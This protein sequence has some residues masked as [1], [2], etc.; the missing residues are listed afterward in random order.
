[1]EQVGE[2]SRVVRNPGDAQL[3]QQ[4]YTGEDLTVLTSTESAVQGL[5][6]RMDAGR[7]ME[8]DNSSQYALYRDAKGFVVVKPEFGSDA[9]AVFPKI[10]QDDYY[11]LFR[12]SRTREFLKMHPGKAIYYGDFPGKPWQ[13]LENATAV[14]TGSPSLNNRVFAKRYLEDRNWITIFE[15]GRIDLG[16]LKQGNPMIMKD[17]SEKIAGFIHRTGVDAVEVPGLDEAVYAKQVERIVGRNLRMVVKT[18]RALI[19]G[20]G[21]AGTYAPK[22]LD[23]PER[24]RSV[25]IDGVKYDPRGKFSIILSNTGNVETPVKIEKL[26]YR[27]NNSERTRMIKEEIL[28][29]ASRKIGYVLPAE[30]GM[31]VERAEITATTYRYI[32][33]PG[34]SSDDGDN[35]DDGDVKK[36]DVE[37]VLA[38]GELGMVGV[39]QSLIQPVTDIRVTRV[40]YS[41]GKNR[42]VFHVTNAGDEEAY[43]QLSVD[44]S[45]EPALTP[46]KHLSPGETFPVALKDSVTSRPERVETTVFQ[47]R[48]RRSL[49]YSS[50]ETLEV[51]SRMPE[52]ARLM[53]LLSLVVLAVFMTLVALNEDFDLP[54]AFNV[55]EN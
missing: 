10:V 22:Y 18:G 3:L 29:P 43:L 16:T 37:P 5:C 32:D 33:P 30:P 6:R 12:D 11:L 26:V 7:C 14:D 19:G 40:S 45:L 31:N 36:S 39:E 44:K 15:P 17:E 51:S 4:Q 47:G 9:A 50:T 55:P 52:P 21:F 28:V 54:D 41:G 38:R 48:D 13:K 2:K 42:L 27:A 20:E 1:A 23:V 24:H 35:D 49:S 34:S 8:L 46:V 53:A 25:S